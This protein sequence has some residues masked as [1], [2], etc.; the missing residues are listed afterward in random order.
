MP[1]IEK[2]TASLERPRGRLGRNW[3]RWVWV[4][5]QLGLGVALQ[6]QC[7]NPCRPLIQE[8]RSIQAHRA[9]PCNR[10]CCG[11]RLSNRRDAEHDH[12]PIGVLH[13]G[14]AGEPLERAVVAM[15]RRTASFA[16]PRRLARK[17]R[18]A[19]RGSIRC[20]GGGSCR[21]PVT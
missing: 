4:G 2:A 17:A 6:S 3:R 19:I 16:L 7:W 8:R 18:G 12:H 9:N 15:L 21:H 1:P 11:L 13:I 5:E 20:R 14:R 10:R